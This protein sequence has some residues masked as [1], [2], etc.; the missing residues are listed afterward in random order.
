VLPELGQRR[1]REWQ[2]PSTWAEFD[3]AQLASEPDRKAPLVLGVPHGDRH[4]V[5]YRLP[6]GWQ[7]AELPADVSLETGFGAFSM[8]WRRE[9]D[10]VVVARSFELQRPRID[11]AEYDAFRDFVL[12]V[13][14]ADGRLVLLREEK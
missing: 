12:A 5:R 7:V 2:L 11:P 8:Q 6:G 4:T 14:S 1:G 3:L 9:G 10:Q 13:K